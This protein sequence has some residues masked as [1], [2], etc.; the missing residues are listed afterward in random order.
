MYKELTG[1]GIRINQT[2]PKVLIEKKVS[3]WLNV[4]SNFKQIIDKEVV[5]EIA[6]E[7][8]IKSGVI[9][10]KEKLTQERLFDAFSINRVYVPA[11]FVINKVDEDP[12]FAETTEGSYIAISAE[13]GKGIEE[14]KKEIWKM[15]KFVT[16]YL[17]KIDA[18]PDNSD[19]I[20]MKEGETLKDVA[21]KIG[22]EF[23]ESKKLVKI[24]GSMAKFSG[25]EVSFGTKV[26]EGMQIRFIG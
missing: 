26:E 16:V 20:V 24:W 23:A 14:L 1:S 17:V 19:P 9:T 22:S 12:K 6:R 15:L 11:I 5:K 21:E 3:G 18:E 13:N 10:L 2:P 7:F 4:F 8:G 25:Q